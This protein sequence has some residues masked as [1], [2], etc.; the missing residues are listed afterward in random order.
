M[1]TW[2]IVKR[3][4]ES[5]LSLDSYQNWVSKTEFSHIQDS[6]LCVAVP[7]EET[8]VWMLSEYSSMVST[9]LQDMGLGVSSVEYEL[10]VTSNNGIARDSYLKDDIFVSPRAQLNPRFTFESFVVGSCN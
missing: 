1:N 5:K 2:D 7:N 9:I 6:R 8:R 10:P 4:L 3:Q